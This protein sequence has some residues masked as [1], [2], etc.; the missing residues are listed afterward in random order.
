MKP[1]QWQQVKHWLAEAMERPPAER[2]AF[3]DTSCTD[4][5]LRQEVKSL[6]LADAGNGGPFWDNPDLTRNMMLLPAGTRLGTYEI[7]AWIGAGGMGLVY[8]ARD[9][10]LQRMVALKVLAEGH[11]ADASARAQL[12]QEAR[13]ASALSHPNI[14]T[15]YETGE[16]GG[17]AYIAMELVEGQSLQ[18]AIGERGLTVSTL[19]RYSHQIAAA[20]AHA[21]ARG[22]VHRDLKPANIGITPEG[23]IK[24]LD[25]GLATRL[26]HSRE[27]A[28][29]HSSPSARQTSPPA[30]TLPYLAPELLRGAPAD[31][32][33][34]IW[35]LG[36][37][38]YEMATG[39][40]PFDR[41]TPMETRE[42]ILRDT[43]PAL[44]PAWPTPVRDLVRQCLAKEPGQRC[45]RA[46]E[47]AA[48]LASLRAQPERPRLPGWAAYAALPA[49]L[50]V[51]AVAYGWRHQ[52]VP[53]PS[54]RG[55]WV[56]LTDFTDSAV[57]PALSPNG[58]LLAFIR[59][60]STFL[61]NGEIEVMR[62]SGGDPRQLTHDGREKMA[63]SFSPDGTTIAYTTGMWDTWQ[64]PVLG[65][66]PRRMLANAEGLTWID[67]GHLL[68]STN[69]D[70]IHMAVVTATAA[71]AESRGVYVPA[72]ER[73]M[74]HRS[75]ISPDHHWV[76][77]AE[78]DNGGWLPCRLLPFHG[79]SAGT[80]I[81]P[82]GAACTYI[83]WSPDQKWMYLSSDKGGR[84]HLWRQRFP[85]GQ[86]EP[87][88]TGAT[89]E[90]GI[91]VAPDGA[92]LITSV[93]LRESTLWVHDARGTRQ[94]SSE[95]FASD[96]HFSP[97]GQRIYYLIQPHGETG[98]FVN[99]ELWEADRAR[100][101]TRRVLPGTSITGYDIS[102]DG[103]E[104]VYS[105]ADPHRI[106]HLWL[107][108]VDH[109]FPPRPFPSAASE[110][111]PHWDDGG[112]IYFRAAEGSLNFLY[113]MNRDGSG[114]ARVSAQPILD[115]FAMAPNGRWAA[116]SRPLGA[117][118]GA[119]V[120]AIPTDGGPAVEMCPGFCLPAWSAVG[121]RLSIVVDTMQGTMTYEY[122]VLPSNGLPRIPPGGPQDIML[123]NG[124]KGRRTLDG[125]VY[126]GPSHGLRAML[127]EEVHRNLYRIPLG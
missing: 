61:G 55:A 8:K 124:I 72:R 7:H 107:A 19:I 116:I 88:T 25:F 59:G 106:S 12:L 70:G 113:R 48:K 62:L 108:S 125:A 122:P 117:T 90:E 67:P 76:L 11:L 120:I 89:E 49:L 21:H 56:Q 10:R 114:R 28:P 82:P 46:S 52:P 63:P 94:I 44:P 112:H 79:G 4:A 38:I 71:G 66:T 18:A 57:S 40:T 17:L 41:P 58:K 80:T 105:V 24:V 13:N 6:L 31:A 69:L 100:A 16:D 98:K 15:I 53:S 54:A 123:A 60:P 81:G 119:N 42:A 104:V 50:A 75:A 115:F 26:P 5:A 91:A 99:G 68:F 103:N 22:I 74:A 23:D 47:L 36:V 9:T 30:G 96:P 87:L 83:A 32:Q 64:V 109:R 84:F 37:V 92:S 95:G 101:H 86:P 2:A 34:D 14:A 77:V 45:Q 43:P 93:G 20:L 118:P 39:V 102:P 33:A 35:A 27:E 73:E 29:A 65:G 111:D 127:R 97:D 121:T 1:E 51:A 3:L 126:L 78:M 85:D 110:D